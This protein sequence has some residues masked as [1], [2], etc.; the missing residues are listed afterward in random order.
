MLIV[1]L[2][3][4]PVGDYLGLDYQFFIYSQGFD[5]M[6]TIVGDSGDASIYD[7]STVVDTLTYQGHPAYKTTHVRV[8]QL[9]PADDS[10]LAWE[11]GDSLFTYIAISETVQ[12]KGYVTPFSIGLNWQLGIV[13]DTLIGDFDGDGIDD[14]L[15]VQIAE[16][17]VIDSLSVTVPLGTF[18]AFEVQLT[19]YCKGW[20]SLINDSCRLWFK[21]RQFL[22]PYLGQVKDSILIEDTIRM[23]NNW[24][25]GM[26]AIMYSEAV[27][28]GYIAVAE[29]PRQSFSTILPIAN[30]IEIT[31]TGEYE[32]G[33]YDI[34]GR[35]CLTKI[36]LIDGSYQFKPALTSGIYFA[37][38]K[39]KGSLGTTKFVIMK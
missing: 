21:D 9:F 1:A 8:S 17:R 38:V 37:R 16:G 15:Y 10:T 14:T 30:G 13:G 23:Y 18:D 39:H 12:I 26:T 35:Q 4:G 28:T 32:I 24:I 19:I 27:D 34:I 7:T 36:L 11:I 2:I 3:A 25:W 6:Y 5:S 33:I 31:G 22:A 29:Q 20:Q